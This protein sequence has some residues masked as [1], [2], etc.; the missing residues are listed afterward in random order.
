MAHL[1]EFITNHWAL[2]LALVIIFVIIFINESLSLKK[3]GKEIS[4][5]ETIDMINN[6]NATVI[7]TRSVELFKQGHIIGAIRASETDFN[8]PKM[9]KYKN[10]PIILV[11]ARGMQSAALATKLRKQEFT[12]V[13]VLAGGMSA[14]Q[15]ANLPVTKK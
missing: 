1:S 10:K 12:Q 8:Q 15:A 9:E 14:W 2:C 5:A 6:Q 11:C 4:T 3:Q 13:M 7:D